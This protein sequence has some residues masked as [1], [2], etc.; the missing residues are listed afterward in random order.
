MPWA[1]NAVDNVDIVPNFA[2]K[3]QMP[4]IAMQDGLSIWLLIVLDCGRR[5]FFR[6]LTLYLISYVQRMPIRAFE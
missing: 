3:L 4:C 1:Q 6:D 5:I 2:Q